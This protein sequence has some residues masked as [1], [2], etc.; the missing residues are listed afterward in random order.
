VVVAAQFLAG[1]GVC[2]CDLGALH[3]RVRGVAA[4]RGRDDGL[5]RVVAQQQAARA[6]D[7]ETAD[8]A[9]RHALRRLAVAVDGAGRRGDA[10]PG[11]AWCKDCFAAYQT[12]RNISLITQARETPIVIA[13]LVNAHEAWLPAFMASAPK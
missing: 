8:G 12:G 1:N 6:V 5:Q 3:H 9:Q 13:D 2:Q 7:D 11:Q 4:P 10:V